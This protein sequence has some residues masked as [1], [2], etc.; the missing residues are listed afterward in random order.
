[1]RTMLIAFAKL[2]GCTSE[3]DLIATSIFANC[4]LLS[5]ISEG[6]ISKKRKK[7]KFW[8]NLFGKHLLLKLHKKMF[9]ST[10]NELF[11]SLS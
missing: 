11:D 8:V 3:K 4:C 2:I 7:K 10:H 1:M 6:N 9:D 5:T